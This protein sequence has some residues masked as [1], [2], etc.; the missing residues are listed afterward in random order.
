MAKSKFT[1]H[2]KEVLK[3][4]RD[5]SDFKRKYSNKKEPAINRLLSNKIPAALQGNVDKAF[6]K[7]FGLVFTKGTFLIEKSYKRDHM[8]KRF[9][10]AHKTA[11]R[12]A[13]RQ[14]FRNFSKRARRSSLLN[15]FISGTVGVLLG[16][17]GIGIPDI[18]I[19][20]PLLLKNIYEIALNFGIDYNK[21]E[22]QA[23]ILLLISTAVRQG[24]D[25]DLA[26]KLLD[27]CIL[28]GSLLP[29]E[30]RE[31]LI[32]QAAKALSDRL[33]YVKFL[34]GI[35]I[36]GAIGGAYDAVFMERI[37]RYAELKYRKRLL[38]KLKKNSD[39]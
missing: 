10:I 20:T 9:Q 31:S 11:L 5:E 7:A 13:D 26:N 6:A 8:E 21:E 17:F 32:S 34:Q 22:E 3:L 18:A 19:F 25:F 23:F 35:P 2:E 28:S 27:D 33:L 24:E 4:L 30:D 16:I 12:F 37:G 29:E 39:A 15:A 36:V 14:A 1:P 38:H